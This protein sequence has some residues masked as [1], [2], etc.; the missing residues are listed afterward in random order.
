MIN[1]LQLYKSRWHAGLTESSHLSNALLTEPEVASTTISRVFGYAGVTALDFLTKG[2]GRSKELTNREYLWYLQG[3]DEKAILIT[4]N[5]GDGG[6]TPGINRQTFRVK[7]QESWFSNSDVLVPDNRDFP[8]RVMGDP[9]FDGTDYV[10]T[11]KLTNPDPTQFMPTAQIAAGMQLSKEYST[12]EEFS[13]TSGDTHFATPF[14]LRNHMSTL[15]KSYSITRSAMTDILIIQAV[16]A[17]TGKKTNMWVTYAEWQALAQ[18]YREVESMLWYSKF[19][20]NPSGLTDVLGTS[21]RPVFSGA[22]IREQISASNKRY[23]TTLTENIIREFLIDL[24]YN[25]RPE[26][27]RKFVAFTGEYGFSEFDKAMKSSASQFV[28]VDSKFVTGQGQELALGGQFTTY[29]GLNGTE[30]TLK[31]LPLY[32]NTIRNRTLHPASKRPIESYRFTIL[33][34]SMYDGESNIQKVY[35]KDSEMVQWYIEG[36]CGPMGTKRNNASSSPVDGYIVH[37]LTE[38]GIMV[39]NPLSCGELILS[40]AS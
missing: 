25:T 39:K 6:A 30:L 20:A 9:E 1:G 36:S 2:L 27:Q 4:G 18:W 8:V 11:L 13:S 26:G 3:D 32:D 34:F 35:K 22:G 24:S 15:R 12:Q 14:A 21:G 17:Q 19:S 7:V 28:L 37:Y 38:C 23:Y 29:R 16:D 31:K 5:F 40:L 33:D 10:L